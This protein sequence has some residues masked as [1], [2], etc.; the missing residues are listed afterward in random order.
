MTDSSFE[1]RTFYGLSYKIHAALHTP[2]D[3]TPVKVGLSSGM[4]IDALYIYC[5]YIYIYMDLIRD[6][7]HIY[8]RIYVY[9]T[10]TLEYSL[11]YNVRILSLSW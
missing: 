6:K 11:F 10:L 7:A 9:S 3:L 4:K 5:I 1:Y 8:V 2:R